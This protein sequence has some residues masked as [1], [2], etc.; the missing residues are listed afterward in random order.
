MFHPSEIDSS[1]QGSLG[2][3]VALFSP[4]TLLDLT[5]LAWFFFFF[6]SLT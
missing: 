4:F 2:G 6:K 1:G 5:E 3:A